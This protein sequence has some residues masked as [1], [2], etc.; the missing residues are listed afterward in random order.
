MRYDNFYISEN[1][2]EYPGQ[3]AIIKLS[4]PRLFLR[5]SYQDGYFISYE[6]WKDEIIVTEW[7][8]GERPNEE[9]QEDILTDC[10][11]FL[12]L[13]EREEDRLSDERFD[14]EL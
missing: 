14:E 5:F 12:A 2:L 3:L 11:N 7:L 1:I 9:E 13:T 4:Y 10:W 6:D 8:D